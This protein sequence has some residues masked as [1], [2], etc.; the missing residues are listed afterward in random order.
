MQPSIAEAAPG[1]SSGSG[2]MGSGTSSVETW[3]YLLP[4][5]EEVAMV[6]SKSSGALIL[7]QALAKG[8]YSHSSF[9][10]HFP[11]WGKQSLSVPGLA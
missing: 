1:N 4:L 2:V 7:F 3:E 11:G 6:T 9:S 5:C 8:P 10:H